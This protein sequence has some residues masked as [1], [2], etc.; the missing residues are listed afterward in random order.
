MSFIMYF[1]LDVIYYNYM[2]VRKDS[3]NQFPSNICF[4]D[5]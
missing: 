5:D 3:I 1:G 4:T 2:E